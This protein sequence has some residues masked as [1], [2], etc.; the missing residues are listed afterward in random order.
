MIH[1][2]LGG[3]GVVLNVKLSSNGE[4]A[5]H[6][7]DQLD[8]LLYQFQPA[9][10]AEQVIEIGQHAGGHN[11]HAVV[12]LGFEKLTVDI[13]RVRGVKPVRNI[14]LIA[15]CHRFIECKAPAVGKDVIPGLHGAHR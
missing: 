1:H 14:R 9:L 8:L 10:R 4:G 5:A 11:G 13:H 12:G 3:N 6:A 2:I 15:G 7:G